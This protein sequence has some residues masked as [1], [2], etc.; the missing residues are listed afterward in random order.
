MG[1]VL[2]LMDLQTL[3]IT[4]NKV[5]KLWKNLYPSR[6]TQASWRY[7]K[8]ITGLVNP[9]SAII[10]LADCHTV[11]EIK[12]IVQDLDSTM[13]RKHSLLR[14]EAKAIRNGSLCLLQVAVLRTRQNLLAEAFRSVTKLQGFSQARWAQLTVYRANN[15]LIIVF[16]KHLPSFFFFTSGWTELQ[17]SDR[18]TTTVSHHEFPIISPLSF[19]RVRT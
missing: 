9:L 19:L 13:L 7:T 15:S 14:T 8:C 18:G 3:T 5:V 6:I 16:S 11:V 4:V 2:F 17:L 10:W 12:R 1:R